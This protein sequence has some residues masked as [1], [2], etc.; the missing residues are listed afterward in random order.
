MGN[1]VQS[2]SVSFDVGLAA[3]QSRHNDDPF[4]DDETPT[5]TPTPT[6]SAD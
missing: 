6:Q 2:D 3:E 4:A 5:P 1:E